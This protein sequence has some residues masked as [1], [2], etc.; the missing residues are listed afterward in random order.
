MWRESKSQTLV[1][2]FILCVVNNYSFRYFLRNV[3]FFYFY[4][5]F[6]LV[7]GSVLASSGFILLLIAIVGI[8]P[9]FSLPSS[10]SIT[11]ELTN[12]WCLRNVL[13]LLVDGCFNYYYYY[14]CQKIISIIIIIIICF[15]Y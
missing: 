15:Y 12:D 4:H 8:K 10:A 14:Y 9:W 13:L 2:M 1:T 6:N 3:F 5:Q 11:T 7:C